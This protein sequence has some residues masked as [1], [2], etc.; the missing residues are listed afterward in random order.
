[1]KKLIKTTI[2]I[3]KDNNNN[4]NYELLKSGCEYHNPEIIKMCL[5]EKI[6]VNNECL[7]LL[8]S[9]YDGYFFDEKSRQEI[10]S[11]INV[12]IQSGGY[13]L[14]KDNVLL[15]T[16][17]YIYTDIKNIDKEYF[18]DPEFKKKMETLFIRNKKFGYGITLSRNSLLEIFKNHPKE[19]KYHYKTYEYNFIMESINKI[20]IIDKELFIA[21][22]HSYLTN[23]EIKKSMYNYLEDNKKLEKQDII[24]LI[25]CNFAINELPEIYKNDAVFMNDL[26]KECKKNNFFAYGIKPEMDSDDLKAFLNKKTKLTTI[27]GLIKKYNIVPNIDCIKHAYQHGVTKSVFGYLLGCAA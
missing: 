6:K 9:K 21:G 12:F 24:E 23:N 10:E 3:I 25:K 14:S 19:N 22:C 4:I 1:M 17:K 27:R 5:N 26:K 16:S 11:C 13:V 7:Q 15:L 20:N 2:E 18:E 8:L